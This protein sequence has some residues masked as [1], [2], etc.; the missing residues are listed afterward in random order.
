MLESSRLNA[1]R[2]CL[3]SCEESR[4]LWKQDHDLATICCD[5]QEQ[6][7]L[8][9]YL[10]DRINRADEAAREAVFAGRQDHSP[11]FDSELESIYGEWAGVAGKCLDVVGELEL[12]GFSVEGAGQMRSRLQEANG[13]LTPDDQ[14]FT[15]D[16]ASEA[17]GRPS[18]IEK[19]V[20]LRDEALAAHRRGETEEM[21]D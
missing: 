12:Q 18:R 2:R 21:E 9:S 10:F 20:Q 19:L 13:L 3:R 6:L 17:D 16:D 15:P 14:F 1:V 11:E 7:A 4:E 5:V 8:L